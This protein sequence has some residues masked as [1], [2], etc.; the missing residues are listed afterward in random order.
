MPPTHWLGI[1]SR[2]S[3]SRR[4]RSPRHTDANT[5][6]LVA[7]G[8][9]RQDCLGLYHCGMRPSQSHESRCTVPEDQPVLNTLAEIT[10]VSV[11]RGTLDAREHMLARLAALV[12]I[13]A[14]AASYV[15][16]FEPSAEVG[17]TVEDVQGLLIAIAPIVGTPRV[18]SAAGKITDA[19]GFVIDIAIAEAELEAE[20]E[21]EEELVAETRLDSESGPGSEAR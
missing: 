6:S 9:V 7:S 21:A 4:Q 10:A 13:D 14:P 20:L 2:S 3:T 15:L 1:L 16:N 12:A 8:Q 17:L 11:A 19:L 18:V 5:Q